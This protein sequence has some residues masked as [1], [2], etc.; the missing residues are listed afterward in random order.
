M[1][2]LCVG[3]GAFI[4]SS[5]ARLTTS[6]YSISFSNDNIFLSNLINIEHCKLIYTRFLQLGDQFDY[7]SMVPFENE[8]LIFA[9]ELR[10]F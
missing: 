3:I 10:S 7:L 9:K 8:M 2:S 5:L 6:L 1:A 4:M